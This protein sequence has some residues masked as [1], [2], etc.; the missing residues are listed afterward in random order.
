EDVAGVV[1]ASRNGVP[2]RVGDLAEVT[3]GA[4]IRQGAVTHDGEGEAVIGIV[5]MR[6]GESAR[7]V[8]HGLRDRIAELSTALPAG[9][10]IE[11]FHDRTE[12]VDRTIRTVRNNLIEGAL[13]VTAVLLLMLGHLRV[14]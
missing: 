10:G 5:M 2:I 1:V 12:L 9:V 11:A 8:T 14:A 3:V 13:L 7:V 6:M 4:M